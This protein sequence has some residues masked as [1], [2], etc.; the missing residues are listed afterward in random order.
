MIMAMV[1]VTVDLTWFPAA[2]AQ[3]GVVSEC[4]YRL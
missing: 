3:K 4:T 2:V 1:K